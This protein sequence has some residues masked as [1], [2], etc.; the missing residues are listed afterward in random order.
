MTTNPRIPP[1]RLDPVVTSIN[2]PRVI[3]FGARV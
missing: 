3:L 1:D 2:P